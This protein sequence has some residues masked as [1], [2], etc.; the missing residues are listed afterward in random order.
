ML[1]GLQGPRLTEENLEERVPLGITVYMCVCGGVCEREDSVI[2]TLNLHP[3]V[4]P[5]P[6]AALVCLLISCHMPHCHPEAFSALSLLSPLALVFLH[7]C[8][9]FCDST[10]IHRYWFTTTPWTSVLCLVLL[11]HQVSFLGDPVTN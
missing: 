6:H 2:L 10:Q 1:G 4:T 5:Y 8:F 11:T 7:N 3:A 9:W